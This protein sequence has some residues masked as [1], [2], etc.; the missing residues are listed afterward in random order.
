MS[1]AFI[2]GVNLYYEVTGRG[3]PLV[4][5][6]EYAGAHES[7]NPQVKYFSRRYQVITYN[8]RGYPPSDV[9]DDLSAYSQEESV[10]D[11]HDLLR[12]LEIQQAYVGGLSMGGNIALNFGIA[13]PEM[14]RALIVAATGS[15]TVDRDRFEQEGTEMANRLETEGM[16]AVAG[17]YAKGPTR[18]QFLRKDPKGWE[19]FNSGLAAH[20]A[21]GSAYTFR[22]L[23]L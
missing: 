10:E 20:S 21:K 6:N 17:E 2:N 18:A 14:A 19:E 15:G 3:F 9:P 5:C 4:W 7:W 12:H 8:A 13:H 1:E 23:I 11:L 22:G 16:K